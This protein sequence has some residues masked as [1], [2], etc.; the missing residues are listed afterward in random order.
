MIEA[1]MV[2]EDAIIR[3]TEDRLDAV[4][5]PSLWADVESRVSGSPR[6]LFL[7]L[8]SVE[9]IDTS[10]LGILEKLRRKMSQNAPLV[11][12]GV[13]PKVQRLLDI[14]GSLDAFRTYPS[15]SE[16]AVAN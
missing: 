11:L 14:L 6:R 15:S 10:G 2:D 7:D 16:A 1:S 8:S 4:N 3:I 5:A 12:T 13:Q 9:L